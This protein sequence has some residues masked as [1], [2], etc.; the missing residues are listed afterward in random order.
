MFPDV[1]VYTQYRK[2]YPYDQ[3][4]RNNVDEV[5]ATCRVVYL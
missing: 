3:T 2:L 1:C 5:C 4:L